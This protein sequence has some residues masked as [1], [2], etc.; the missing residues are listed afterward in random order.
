MGGGGLSKNQES[1][2]RGERWLACDGAEMEVVEE[3]GEQGLDSG[4][5]P[6]SERLVCSTF[7]I[8]APF[9]K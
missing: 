5:A 3:G 7:D 8:G 2:Y 6:S 9:F 4:C 1:G